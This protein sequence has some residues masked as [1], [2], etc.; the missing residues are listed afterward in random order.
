[1]S[2]KEMVE[3]LFVLSDIL[4]EISINANTTTRLSQNYGFQKFRTMIKTL[5]IL[6]DMVE[7]DSYENVGD[8]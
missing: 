5:N 4:N 2:Q 1:M 8:E 3:Q 7:D 6:V